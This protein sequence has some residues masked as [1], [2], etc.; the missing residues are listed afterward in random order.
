MLYDVRT[1][2]GQYCSLSVL[3]ALHS[4]QLAICAPMPTLSPARMPFTF[5]PTRVTMPT[6]SWP[7]IMGRSNSP[8]PA[9]MVWMSEPQ[10]PQ[11][12]MRSSTSVVPN[13]FGVKS[14]TEKSLCVKDTVT[15]LREAK[16]HICAPIS[17]D[18]DWLSHTP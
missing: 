13:V 8:Q 9:V 6:I 7:T 5:S 15:Q 1:E 12:V 11:W 10:T 14:I 2:S 16:L 17:L 4:P 18:P 3:H